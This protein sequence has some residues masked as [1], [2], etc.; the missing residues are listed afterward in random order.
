MINR[1]PRRG[2]PEINASSTA[3]IAFLLLI[4]FLLTTSMDTDKGLLRRLPP[5]AVESE[6]EPLKLKE[7]NV[8]VVSL[9]AQDRLECAGEPVTL[10]ELH[11][12]ARR[13]IANPSDDPDLPEKVMTEVPY[14]GVVPVT[15]HHVIFLQCHREATY[16]AYIAVQDELVAVYAELRDELARRKWQCAYDA[17]G[18]G[19]K[20]AVRMVFPQKIA[21]TELKGKEE[22]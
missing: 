15:E 1:R 2:V 3:D 16:K 17:L 4:F 14:L 18:D 7:R 22:E 6:A 12:R 11:D 9:D 13:F 5:A 10:D 8:L 19:Q 21:E 20:Q